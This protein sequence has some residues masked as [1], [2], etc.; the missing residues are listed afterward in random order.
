MPAA[1]WRGE[2][3]VVD[4]DGSGLRRLTHNWKSDGTPAW[5]PDGR[6]ILF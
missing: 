5:S 6:K 4:A 1:L 3:Y 2:I